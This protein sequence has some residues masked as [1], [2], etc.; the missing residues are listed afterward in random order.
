MATY[1][2]KPVQAVCVAFSAL[3]CAPTCCAHCPGRL[4]E[5]VLK[6]LP[7]ST[8]QAINGEAPELGDSPIKAGVCA[9]ARIRAF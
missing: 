2:H 7:V 5:M 3:S 9:R 6:W 8:N 4:K 1:E